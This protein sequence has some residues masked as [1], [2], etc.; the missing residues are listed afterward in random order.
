MAKIFSFFFVQNRFF[1]GPID[2]YIMRADSSKSAVN[3]FVYILST[4]KNSK[5]IF[6]CKSWK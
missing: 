1:G 2:V 4:K 6:S 5:L 3:R